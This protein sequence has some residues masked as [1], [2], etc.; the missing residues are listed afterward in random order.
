MP[1]AHDVM[2][3]GTRLRTGA[4]TQTPFGD[5]EGQ[6]SRL[7]FMTRMTFL[8]F[9]GK[10]ARWFYAG[11]QLV[12]Q[13]ISAQFCTP[14]TGC[15]ERSNLLEHAGLGRQLGI[16]STP[17]HCPGRVAMQ[18]SYKG[19][20]R[21][22]AVAC[23]LLGL[24][25]CRRRPLRG[26][27]PASLSKRPVTGAD[28]THLRRLPQRPRAQ[29]EPLARILRR[30][31]RRTASRHDREDDPQ[32]ARGSDAA[33]GLAAA[34]RSRARKPG[35]EAGGG[36]GRADHGSR[37]GTKKLSAAQPHGIRAIDPR[38]ARARRECGRVPAA[39]REERQLRQHRRRAA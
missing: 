22:L 18:E 38:S 4:Q 10:R 7:R 20:M 13:H 9:G 29:R 19:T 27:A 1:L 31:D 25:G 28:R 37:A 23:L 26:S 6:F 21:P 32:A 3:D 2:R 24:C 39:R 35:G 15:R 33:G 16:M 34:G 14:E 30:H 8:P 11:A 12:S 17:V 5:P 36:S